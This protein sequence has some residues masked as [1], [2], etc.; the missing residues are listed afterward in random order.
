[1]I[2]PED[3]DADVGFSNNGNK[4]NKEKKL[5]DSINERLNLSDY[6]IGNNYSDNIDDLD[7]FDRK[8][9]KN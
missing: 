7:S 6:S 9:K 1:M 8:L 4:T 2:E 5:N 3:I